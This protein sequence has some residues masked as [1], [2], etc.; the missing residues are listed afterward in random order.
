MAHIG[1][2]YRVAFRRDMS[3][4]S[5]TPS[6]HWPEYFD[7]KFVLTPPGFIM[8]LQGHTFRCGPANYTSIN[9]IQW[10]SQPILHGA[11]FWIV[12]LFL[13]IPPTPPQQFNFNMEL[14]TLDPFFVYSEHWQTAEGENPLA[15]LSHGAVATFF[16][17]AFFQTQQQPFVNLGPTRWDS[18]APH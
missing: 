7:Y 3:L 15:S 18:P 16:N 13:T 12:S 1:R 14:T 17:P 10:D 9:T 11:F 2:A 8:L 5:F 4:N 6:T